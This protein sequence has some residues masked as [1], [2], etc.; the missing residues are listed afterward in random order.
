MNQ[1][2]TLEEL[3]EHKNIATE[4]KPMETMF[5]MRL[6]VEYD[7]YMSPVIPAVEN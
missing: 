2:A 7:Q 3:F 6:V 1:H 4:K 5:S